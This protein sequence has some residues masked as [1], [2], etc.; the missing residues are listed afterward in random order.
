MTWILDLSKERNQSSAGCKRHNVGRA[1][2]KEA[3]IY[4]VKETKVVKK[5]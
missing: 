3:E 2:R 4:Q 1:R 5:S